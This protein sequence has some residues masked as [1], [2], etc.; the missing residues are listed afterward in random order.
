VKREKRTALPTPP[1]SPERLPS[2]ANRGGSRSF[3][4]ALPSALNQDGEVVH[5]DGRNL[6][7]RF[8]DQLQSAT[9]GSPAIKDEAPVNEEHNAKPLAGAKVEEQSLDAS[10]ICQRN[11]QLLT[12]KVEEVVR[13]DDRNL[14]NS[15]RDPSPSLTPVGSLGPSIKKDEHVSEEHDAKPLAGVPAEEQDSDASP[16]RQ[17]NEQLPTPKVEEVVQNLDGRNLDDRSRDPSP[18]PTP[19]RSPKPSIK[20]EEPVGEKHDAKPFADPKVA[21]KQDFD[22]SPIRQRIEVP[23]QALMPNVDE[24]EFKEKSARKK[25]RVRGLF[26]RSLVSLF[27]VVGCLVGC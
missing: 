20:K 1:A 19:V 4:E 11:E 7:D 14:D 26:I 27:C 25:G 22:A 17:R 13:L 5:L 6:Y 16:I 8:R 9:L 2:L 10:P 12:P 15:I 21:E 23:H 24:A 3:S 18:S